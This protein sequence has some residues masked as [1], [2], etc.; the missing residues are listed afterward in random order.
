M[1]R[2]DLTQFVVFRTDLAADRFLATWRPIASTFLAAGLE[3]ITLAA[4][5]PAA[6]DGIGFVSRNT[7]PEEAYRRYFGDGGATDGGGGP[8]VVEQAGVF[9]V[10]P[11]SPAPVAAARPDTDLTLALLPTRGHGPAHP[12]DRAVVYR[13]ARPDQRFDAA[14]MLHAPPGSGTTDAERLR[15]GLRPG[16]VVLSG[17]EVLSLGLG[18]GR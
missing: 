3:T 5:D 7:W 6:H 2:T 16:A 1:P 12:D 10:A 18:L 15:A 13:G 8:V 4:F 17:V 11:G 9:T 14:V